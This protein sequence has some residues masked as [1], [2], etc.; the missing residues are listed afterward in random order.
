MGYSTGKL[1]IIFIV[2][3]VL[4]VLGAWLLAWR[5]RAAMRVLM[6]RPAGPPTAAYLAPTPLP[7]TL[8][9]PASLSA[10]D[11]RRAG[12]RLAALLVALSAL[13][14]LT[15]ALLQLGL[16]FENLVTPERTLTLAF[17]YLWPV[18][19]VLGQM[20]RWSRLR[21]ISVLLLWGLVAVP[22]LGWRMNEGWAA[23]ETS[24]F[25]V[26][27][28][29]PP[30]LLVVVLCMGNTTRAIAPWLFLPLLVLVWASFTGLDL[31][32]LMLKQQPSL[33][34]ALT[35][36][37]NTFERM[38]LYNVLLLLLFIALPCVLAWWPL[39]WLSRQLAAAYSR[40]WLS[41]LLV[42]FTAVW[43]IS[44]VDKAI[45][46][47]NRLGLGGAAMLVPL[48]WIPPVMVL[49]RRLRHPVD[50]PP[51]LLVLRVF[52][53]DRAMRA[54]FDTVIE[55]WRLSGNTLLIAGTDLLD[56]TLD[57]GDIFTFLDG[58]LA[59]RFILSADQIPVSLAA[60]ELDPDA[61]GRY[62]VNEC[63]CHDGIWRDTLAALLA[64]S[65]VV[66]M[67][68]RS[69]HRRNEGCAFE[70]GEL[71]RVPHLA[72]VVALTDAQTDRAAAQAAAAAAPTGR[73]V[74]LDATQIDRAKRREVLNA[75]FVAT[76][77]GAEENRYK[78]GR[79]GTNRA[80]RP[81]GA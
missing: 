31:L 47:G 7:A 12:W 61:E 13:I 72:R 39:K 71:A 30:I 6:R 10:A 14:S 77:T 1:I 51:T 79:R 34:S 16:A 57:A 63:Y 17:A 29:G 25:L 32:D 65:D 44:L 78:R 80:V 81:G 3:A 52:Q 4:S 37:V 68:L 75:L 11:N 38:L 23:A 70:L 22:V 74:W 24:L 5:F 15:T 60:F 40:Q 56:R 33:L 8:T 26:S 2:P 55:R 53:R 73:F 36:W 50:R 66:L 48:L 42:L 49:L 18:I 64:R 9:A 41:E 28:I 62:R 45:N 43:G 27:E 46:V 69:F 58:R 20:W 21:V 54:L 76:P 35:G 59:E 19:P 67:D